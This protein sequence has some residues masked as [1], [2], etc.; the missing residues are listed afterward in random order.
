MEEIFVIY[1][2][3][4]IYMY[5]Y[6]FVYI[7]IY[8]YVYTSVCVCAYVYVYQY[9]YLCVCVYVCVCLC[10]FISMYTCIIV[11][12]RAGWIKTQ[13]C[14]YVYTYIIDIYFRVYVC[15]CAC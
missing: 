14:Q 4:Y 13:I 2:D 10:I 1:I 8:I 12:H 9:I 7:Y 15:L 6:I 11:V 5:I 3:C